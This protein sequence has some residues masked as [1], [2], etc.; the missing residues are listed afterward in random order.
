VPEAAA[1]LT[2]ILAAKKM[3]EG[4]ISARAKLSPAAL[5]L[6]LSGEAKSVSEVSQEDQLKIVQ[7]IPETLVLPQPGDRRE[8]SWTMEP[9]WQPT[10][11]GQPWNPVDAPRLRIKPVQV[12]DPVMP[13]IRVNI[14][15]ALEDVH[16][17]DIQP[18]SKEMNDRLRNLVHNE[19]NEAAAKQHLK[20]VLKDAD[21]EPQSMDNRFSN[22]M[23]AS[24]LATPE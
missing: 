11:Q 17:S 10:L 1:E 14:T 22:L 8:Y 3:A 7:T 12:L 23:I 24:I 18:K 15:C 16:I 6:G 21:L 20:L 4:K 19:I 5:Y 9:S 2:R 13:A